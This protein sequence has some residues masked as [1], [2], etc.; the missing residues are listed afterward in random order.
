[1]PT[2]MYSSI[3]AAPEGK[4]LKLVAIQPNRRTRRSKA[5]KRIYHLTGTKKI[6]Y[7][8]DGSDEYAPM[9]Y[10][11]QDMQ[12]FYDVFVRAPLTEAE[13]WWLDNFG[14]VLIEEERHA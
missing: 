1:M 10:D 11:A 4:E 7:K 2:L 8:I 14:Y 13:K 12:R 9:G 5:G 6:Y 3:N